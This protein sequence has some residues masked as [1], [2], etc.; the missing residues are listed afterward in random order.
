MWGDG[1][2][3]QHEQFG[4]K[5]SLTLFMGSKMSKSALLVPLLYC[6]PSIRT[7]TKKSL[8]HTTQSPTVII[9]L[10]LL[11]PLNAGIEITLALVDKGKREADV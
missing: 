9:P 6:H 1:G 10:C 4:L 2:V 3:S 11:S 5:G 8:L 7:P